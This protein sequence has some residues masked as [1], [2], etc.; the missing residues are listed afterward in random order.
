MHRFSCLELLWH[1]Y[2][3]SVVHKR[4][5]DRTKGWA[6]GGLECFLFWR[7]ETAWWEDKGKKSPELEDLKQP[8][9]HAGVEEVHLSGVDFLQQEQQS[10]TP[11]P[12]TLPAVP[13]SPQSH[14]SLMAL[15]PLYPSPISEQRGGASPHV[16]FLHRRERG[17]KEKKTDW[18]FT[19]TKPPSAALPSLQQN[20]SSHIFPICGGTNVMIVNGCEVWAELLFQ[21][22][23]WVSIF[24]ESHSIVL[25][26]S[27][28]IWFK[29]AVP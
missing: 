12:L 25:G 29:C 13:D 6:C 2:G 10:S 5:L 23:L 14:L 18:K 19:Q 17:R 9:G 3:V 4:T 16:T 11:P 15:H 24:Y 7:N 8:P 28:R 22:K 27:S 21:V 1:P 20:I 26:H